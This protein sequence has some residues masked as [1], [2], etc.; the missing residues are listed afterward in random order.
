[1]AASEIKLFI[2]VSIWSFCTSF[3]YG[4]DDGDR[5]AKNCIQKALLPRK[6]RFDEY[7]R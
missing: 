5:V 4:E 1:M 2:I 6:A 3:E 7:Y